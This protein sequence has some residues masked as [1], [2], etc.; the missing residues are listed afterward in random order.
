MFESTFIL[1]FTHRDC[2]EIEEQE[3]TAASTAW[4]AFRAFAEPDS[5]E[6]YHRIALLES[7]GRTRQERPLAQMTFPA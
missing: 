7:S 2:S 1:R 4:E 5:S 6:I 3:H